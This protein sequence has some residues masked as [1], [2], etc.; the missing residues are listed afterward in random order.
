MYDVTFFEDGSRLVITTEYG[1]KV[2]RRFAQFESGK[3]DIG[4]SLIYTE[5][6]EG[7]KSYIYRIAPSQCLP[8]EIKDKTH[9]GVSSVNANTGPGCPH[10][11]FG[12]PHRCTTC[13]AAKERLE[14][15]AAIKRGEL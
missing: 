5:K 3:D 1:E 2:A 14:L 9:R 4:I 11:K 13:I 6:T 10:S 8:D 15:I 12:W 7:K